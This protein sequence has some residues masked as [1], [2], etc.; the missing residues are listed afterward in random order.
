VDDALLVS[1]GEALRY[2]QREF[3]RLLLGNGTR[4][5]LSAQRLAF[6]ELHHGV[7]DAI[8]ASEIVNREDVRM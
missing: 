3:H 5:E 6:Q 7:S 1:G 4:V 8:L 2:L